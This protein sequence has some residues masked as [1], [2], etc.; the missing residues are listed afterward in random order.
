[1]P[2]QSGFVRKSLVL[3]VLYFIVLRVVLYVYQ[4]YIASE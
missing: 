4:K 2:N 3:G 1:M